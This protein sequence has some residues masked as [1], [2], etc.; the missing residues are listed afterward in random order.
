MRL[1]A[2]VGHLVPGCGPQALEDLGVVV[3]RRSV[4]TDDEG[5][6]LRPE[7]RNGRDV[8]VRPVAADEETLQWMLEPLARF[9]D[10]RQIQIEVGDAHAVARR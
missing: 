8:A 10:G 3:Q 2:A 6:P 9:D 7:G 4:Q 1:A 5:Q